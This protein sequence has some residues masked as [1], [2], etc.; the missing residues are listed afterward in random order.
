MI[1]M[2]RTSWSDRLLAVPG[3]PPMRVRVGRIEWRLLEAR[4]AGRSPA[5]STARSGRRNLWGRL[6]AT[7]TRE[8]ER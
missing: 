6:R 3:R 5:R 4:P 2:R 8:M 7:L 1:R